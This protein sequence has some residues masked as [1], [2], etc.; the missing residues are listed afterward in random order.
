MSMIFELH[1]SRIPRTSDPT[2]GPATVAAATPTAL[3]Q[4]QIRQRRPQQPKPVRHLRVDKDQL[5]L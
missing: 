2:K 4:L 3:L 1:S 5:L